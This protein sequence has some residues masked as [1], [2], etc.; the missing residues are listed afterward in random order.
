MERDNEF[1]PHYIRTYINANE[2]ISPFVLLENDVV[3]IQLQDLRK[4]NNKNVQESELKQAATQALQA[5][6]WLQEMLHGR[7]EDPK[8]GGGGGAGG[9][10][11]LSVKIWWTPFEKQWDGINKIGTCINSG[12][13]DRKQNEILIWRHQDW[14]YV[15]LHEY[16]HAQKFDM[17]LPFPFDESWVTF[18]G[19]FFHT[20]YMSEGEQDLAC[21]W[22]SQYHRMERLARQVLSLEFKKRGT[23][24][25]YV[26]MAFQVMPRSENEAFRIITEQDR[27]KLFRTLKTIRSLPITL[28]DFPF[29]LCF[30]C[31]P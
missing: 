11:K 7:K 21:K 10:K 14:F 15:L 19:L 22:H 2:A 20:L 18:A 31:P 5:W 25:W 27:T 8:K 26:I 4:E 30:T 9:T 1:C 23:A 24:Q 17:G 13:F 29:S 3:R 12:S 6:Q 28:D 16:L